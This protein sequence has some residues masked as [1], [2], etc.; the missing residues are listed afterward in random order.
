MKI[1]IE[2]IVI[3]VLYILLFFGETSKLAPRKI[4]LMDSIDVTKTYFQTGGG[5][6]IFC[7]GT[8]NLSFSELYMKYG[9]EEGYAFSDMLWACI[10][11]QFGFGGFVSFLVC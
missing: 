1:A 7:S 6:A 11:G 9:Y 4:L 10:V 2:K 3:G 8:E 5:F